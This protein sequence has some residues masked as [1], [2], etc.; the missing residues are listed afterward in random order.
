MLRVYIPAVLIIFL[1]RG[2]V[3]GQQNG[4]QKRTIPVAVYSKQ[5]TPPAVLNP[6]DFQGSYRG[7][8]VHIESITLDDRSH[9]LILLLDS[10]RSMLNDDWDVSLEVADDL[11]D[12]VPAI[13]RIG[14]AWFSDKV[15]RRIQPSN[16]REILKNE[17]EQLRKSGPLL[18]KER[19]KTALWDALGESF[20]MIDQ[21]ELGDAIYVITDGEDNE[22]K[23]TPDDITPRLVAA[24]VRVFTL[25]F[26]S[27]IRTEGE[28]LNAVS[29][30]QVVKD[31]GGFSLLTPHSASRAVSNQLEGFLSA[32]YRLIYPF[33][34][35]E[36]VLAK[37]V[38]R[39]RDWDLEL[40]DLG[41]LNK[42]NLG[43]I[44]PAKLASCN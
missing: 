8:P 22:S 4:C 32:Q 5:P 14:M 12:K 31:T 25:E 27:R 20:K 17:V 10:S 34:H 24:G 28:T 33:L 30:R 7:Q 38:D 41:T 44:Y 37:P 16:D 39:L 6:N 35:L 9:R 18:R 1:G 11:L 36:F 43:V 19:R 15:E 13:N 2:A 21:P 26:A 23:A 3:Y 29:L 40:A 42:K